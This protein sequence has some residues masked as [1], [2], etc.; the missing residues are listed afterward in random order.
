MIE[1][2]LLFEETAAGLAVE[3]CED[4]SSGHS[5]KT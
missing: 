3:A 2:G 4:T 1:Q 5:D